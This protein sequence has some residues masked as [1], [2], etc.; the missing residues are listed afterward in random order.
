[1][2]GIQNNIITN[3]RGK[4]MFPHACVYLGGRLSLV[5][6]NFRGGRVSGGMGGSVLQCR[7]PGR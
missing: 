6:V 5:P 1:M 2:T 4:V 3:R 7:V